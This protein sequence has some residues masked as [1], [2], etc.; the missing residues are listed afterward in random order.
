VAGLVYG[1]VQGYSQTRKMNTKGDISLGFVNSEYNVDNLV[2]NRLFMP[3]DTTATDSVTIAEILFNPE[4]RLIDPDTF[5]L[6]T[7]LIRIDSSLLN[8]DSTRII[9]IHPQDVLQANEFKLETS[10][11]QASLVFYGSIRV[12]GALDYNGLQ[13][14]DAFN[15]Y[16][17]PV[18]EENSNVRRFYMG[19]FQTRIGIRGNNKTSYGP[20][21]FKIEA[22]FRGQ[23]R[24]LRI[25]HAYGQFINILAGQT[26]SVFG[27]PFSIPWTVDLEGPNSSLNRRSVQIRYS[28]LINEKIRYMVSLE[29]PQVEFI[30]SDSIVAIIQGFPD[31]AARIKFMMSKGHIQGAVILRSLGVSNSSEQATESAGYGGLLS[32]R[33]DFR[34]RRRLLFQLVGGVGIARYISSLK[35]TGSDV[36]FN[37]ATGKYEPL[38]VFGGFV[39]LAWG[40]NKNLYSFLTPGFTSI[41][42]KRYQED[43]SF[44]FSAY[45]SVN[46]FYDVTEGFRFGAEY[47]YGSRVDKNNEKGS[48]NRLSFVFYYS[49]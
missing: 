15:T 6:E 8:R 28:N 20:V 17:I 4:M 31:V 36:V 33:Y 1:V 21:N 23:Y 9:D 35:G 41:K 37:P 10:N 11:K 38:P 39:S 19:A 30:P 22:D 34:D 26:W 32:G 2:P 49:F 40:W 42:N 27:D 18:G 25:R 43:D 3:V 5:K 24:N 14:T 46:T 45:F 48:A 16:Y 13:S 29:T 12:N 44:S 7:G 47:S